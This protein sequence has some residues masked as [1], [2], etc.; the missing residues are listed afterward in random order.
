MNSLGIFRPSLRCRNLSV[1]DDSVRWACAGQ[2]GRAAQP[3]EETWQERVPLS[4]CLEL[5]RDS[6]L[7]AVQAEAPAG[8]EG[9]G[10]GRDRL[11][12]TRGEQAQ[13]A[14]VTVIALHQRAE[15]G[16]LDLQRGAGG[17]VLARP[18]QRAPLLWL[19]PIAE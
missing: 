17:T 18:L 6:R 12:V 19:I 9:Q 5:H 14:K 1:W 16:A 8:L 11:D 13:E 2:G 15:I 4:G 10:T 7:R 3:A